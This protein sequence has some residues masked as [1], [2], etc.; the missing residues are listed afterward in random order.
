MNTEILTHI[1][2]F[3]ANAISEERKELLQPLIDYIQLKKKHSERIQLNFICTH[4]SRRSQLAQVWAQLL[5]HYM[6]INHVFCYSGGTEITEVF[7]KIV[8][9]LIHQGIKIE[10]L[11]EDENPVY[12]V[13]YDENTPP[14]TCFSKQYNDPSNPQHHFAA[15]MTCSSADE[16]CPFVAGAEARF[17]LQYDDP[18]IFDETPLQ[19][20]KYAERSLEIGQEMWYVFSKIK[21]AHSIL[22]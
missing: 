12:A 9:T 17:S 7:P 3:S 14:I 11:S 22:A 20:A 19:D 15:I 8:E 13:T 21:E 18:K 4:N 10:K 6:G 16:G 1:N 5:A 2:A